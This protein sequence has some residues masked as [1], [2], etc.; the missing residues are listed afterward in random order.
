VLLFSLAVSAFIPSAPESYYAFT[1]T[2]A[3]LQSVICVYL[4]TSITALASFFGPLAIQHVMS[5][6]AAVAVAISIAQLLQRNTRS[7][8]KGRPRGG[9]KALAVGMGSA[10]TSAAIFFSI[11]TFIMVCALVTHW[12]LRRMPI[13]HEVVGSFETHSGNRLEE[14]A[15]LL[16]AVTR[17]SARDRAVF[18]CQSITRK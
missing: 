8:S 1:F 10:D 11:S 13:Y 18:A 9:Q 17:E 7:R 5:G 14:E 6:Q 4:S 3:T 15:A 12:Y 16:P 2:N